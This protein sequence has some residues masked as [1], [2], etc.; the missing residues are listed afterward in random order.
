MAACDKF[1]HTE[2][3]AYDHAS[4][5]SRADAVTL[6]TQKLTFEPAA[7]SENI[8]DRLQA[9]VRTFAGEDGWASLAQVG[10]LVNTQLP[11]FD[12][13]TFGYAKLGEFIIDQ[14]LFEYERKPPGE[15]KPPLAYVREHRQDGPKPRRTLEPWR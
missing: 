15:G 3:L 14:N 10:H 9:A 7:V 8:V 4:A 6:Q 12:T 13:R 5:I 1:V 2:N 11:D